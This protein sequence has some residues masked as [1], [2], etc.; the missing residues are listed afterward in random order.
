MTNTRPR[1]FTVLT[2]HPLPLDENEVA[3]FAENHPQLDPDI[4]ADALH[5][6]YIT[7]LA[8]T[9]EWRVFTIDLYG[10]DGRIYL[11]H[12]SLGEG[13]AVPTDE[14]RAGN[15]AEAFTLYRQ[16]IADNVSRDDLPSTPDDDAECPYCGGEISSSSRQAGS[17]DQRCTSCGEHRSIG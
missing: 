12:G 15:L 6:D 8:K 7:L 11:W 14:W 9:S 17:V 5:E 16:A 3:A 10:F 1:A 13:L 2:E 4:H